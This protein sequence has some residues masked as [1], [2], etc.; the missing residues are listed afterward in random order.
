M[1]AWELFREEVVSEA[2]VLARVRK[3]GALAGGEPCG[4]TRRGID[5]LGIEVEVM[6]A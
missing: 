5:E 4:E 2:N 6:E 3:I 1:S